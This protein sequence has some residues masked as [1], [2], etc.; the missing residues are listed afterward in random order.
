MGSEIISPKETVATDL[1]TRGIISN[2]VESFKIRFWK[3][4]SYPSSI[5][6]HMETPFPS[7]SKMMKYDVKN[8]VGGIQT[9]NSKFA[10]Y[11]GQTPV[12]DGL[13][14]EEEDNVLRELLVVKCKVT[15]TFDSHGKVCILLILRSNIVY[16][17]FLS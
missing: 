15:Y 17:Y 7:A 3:L 13:F 9:L 8:G 16:S 12:F 14:T 5:I 11:G 6:P 1:E 10:E 2:G 4:D